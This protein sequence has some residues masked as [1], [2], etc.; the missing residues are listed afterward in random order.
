MYYRVINRGNDDEVV[1]D[2]GGVCVVF[3]VGEGVDK[4]RANWL[5]NGCKAFN[6]KYIIFAQYISPHLT[7]NEQEKSPWYIPKVHH[8]TPPT[9]IQILI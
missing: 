7:N 3:I 1:K 2:G 4:V 8:M 5:P 6:Q 9:V